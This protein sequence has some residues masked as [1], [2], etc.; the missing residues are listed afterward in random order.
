MEQLASL[1]LIGPPIFPEGWG[2]GTVVPGDAKSLRK[3]YHK[4]TAKCHPDKTRDLPL[5][6]QALAE[7]LFK[8]MGEAYQKELARLE[9]RGNNDAPHQV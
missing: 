7:E 8:A 1:P 6:A 9:A 4:A 2:A 5:I 3:A